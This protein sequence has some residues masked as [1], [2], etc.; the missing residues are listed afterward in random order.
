MDD[1]I[2]IEEPKEYDDILIEHK[3][4][5]ITLK[6]HASSNQVFDPSDLTESIGHIKG[7]EVVIDDDISIEEY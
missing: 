6:Y 3:G 2:S 5:D 4:S 1:D 7:D